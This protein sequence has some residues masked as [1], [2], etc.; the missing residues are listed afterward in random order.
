[1]SAVL[2]LY[3]RPSAF[4]YSALL[5]PCQAKPLDNMQG[6]LLVG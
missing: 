5:A 3:I 6:D 4:V 2:L 1:M